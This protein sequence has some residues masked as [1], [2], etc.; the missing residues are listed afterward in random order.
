MRCPAR[1][2][3]PRPHQA[4]ELSCNEL[5]RCTQHLITCVQVI[6]I[7]TLGNADGVGVFFPEGLLGAITKPTGYNASSPG[8]QAYPS[9]LASQPADLV[10]SQVRLIINSMM[11]TPLPTRH[12]PCLTATSSGMP[13]RPACLRRPC[14]CG[15]P[16]IT[17]DEG[18]AGKYSLVGLKPLTVG[19]GP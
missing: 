12:R 4:M 14:W 16:C 5:L 7:L 18:R 3:G 19:L 8:N 11:L 10:T 1:P 9:Q 15:N 13:W 6:N 2:W 17:N